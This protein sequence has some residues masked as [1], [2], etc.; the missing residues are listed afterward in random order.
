MIYELINDLQ[1]D[2]NHYK[3]C[4]FKKETV[5]LSYVTLSSN[6]AKKECNMAIV[7]VARKNGDPIYTFSSK[8]YSGTEY[9]FICSLF[10][11]KGDLTP[12]GYEYALDN[13]LIN[14]V[15]LRNLISGPIEVGLP[16]E[17]QPEP[18]PEPTPEPTPEPEPE[19]QP[20]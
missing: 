19:P 6:P 14:N 4:F 16:Q 18:Q 15:T 17:P 9:D 11:N 2:E 1:Y 13:F 3:T 12:S 20:E 8:G 5:A 10:D 7:A